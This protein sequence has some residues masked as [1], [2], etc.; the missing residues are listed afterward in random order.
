MNSGCLQTEKNLIYYAYRFFWKGV[1]QLITYEEL[2][3]LSAFSETGTLSE[4][5]ERFHI[6]QPTITRS[7]KKIEEE[8]GVPLFDRTKNSIKLIDN[9]QLAAEEAG[10]LLRQH[11]S[12][13]RRVRAYDRANHTI[14]IGS[15]AAVQIPELI[16]KVTE[17]NPNATISTE[18]K[19][20]AE[21]LAGLENGAYQL[22]VLPYEPQDTALSTVK[23]GEEHLMFFLPKK[24]RF[25][26]RKFLTLGELNGENMLLFSDIGFWHDIVTE[27]MPNSRF[28]V[29]NERYSFE[30]LILNSVLPCFTTDISYRSEFDQGGRVRV[31][32]T[33][34]EV[35]VSYY[36]VCKKEN[37]KRFAALF[38]L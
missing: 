23:I 30:E 25:A 29:Q 2:Q 27:K 38:N 6:S 16:R 14:S 26:K 36:L 8:F 32:I 19:K 33:D 24:H 21:L 17:Q 15:A 28:L 31:P 20:L 34:P 1:A 7:M 4:V 5:A 18:L 10:M 37:E 12:M 11:E 3:Y 9:G 22:I 13:L 35:N